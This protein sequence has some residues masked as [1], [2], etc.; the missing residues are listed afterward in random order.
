MNTPHY[1]MKEWV[2]F[3]K[4][5]LREDVYLEMEHHLYHCDQCL[6]IFSKIM[7]EDETVPPMTN[8]TAFTDQVMEKVSQIDREITFDTGRKKQK[9]AYVKQTMIHYT[10]AASLTILLMFSGTF[11]KLSESIG[12]VHKTGF[13]QNES[14]TENVLNKTLSLLDSI[15]EHA[16]EAKTE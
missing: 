16:E 3:A 15:K 5:E 4:G 10:I 2:A 1:S 6:A 7:I 13:E 11:E 14:V 12:N 9:K 8:G